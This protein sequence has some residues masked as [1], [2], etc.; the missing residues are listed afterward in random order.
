MEIEEFYIMIFIGLA[1]GVF[2][3][4][5]DKYI[6]TD[7]AKHEAIYKIILLFILITT[8]GL[9]LKYHLL[10]TLMVLLA[11]MFIDKIKMFLKE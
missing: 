9:A 2:S 5:F 3:A 1:Y 7:K 11:F 6:E 8:T 10:S 4:V